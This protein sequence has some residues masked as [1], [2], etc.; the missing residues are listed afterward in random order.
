MKIVIAPDSFK[1][2]LSAECVA[3]AIAAGVRDA[4]PDAEILCVPM[5]DGGEG[6]LDAV[7]AATH[8]ERRYSEVEG[9]LG[10]PVTAQWGWLPGTLTAVI[11]MAAASGIHLVAPADRDACKA[12]T[13]GTGQLIVEAIEAGAQRI[14]LGFGGS[15]TNDGGSGMLCALGALFLDSSGV[16][17][18]QGG[19]D[20]QRLHYL[21]LGALDARL[22][23]IAFEVA[24][25]VDSPLCGPKGASHV[26]GPQK[27]ATPEQVLALDSALERYADIC[28]STFG[29][30][31]RGFKGA[32]AAGGIGYAAKMFLHASFRPGVE[33]VADLSNLAEAVQGAD[34]VITG[35]GRIDE[36]TLYGKTPA[37]V[38]AVAMAAGVPV[39]AIAGTLGAG[40]QRLRGIGISAAFSIT[41]GPMTLEAACS[42]AAQLLRERSSEVMRLWCLGR[43]ANQPVQVDSVP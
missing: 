29:R 26:F 22:Q 39:I 19:L 34:L 1:E 31:E 32:G 7:L 20:L 3:Q 12:S 2:S 10:Q 24:C 11:E 30:D 33:L 8:G 25:D 5:A 23:A 16:A 13:Y 6:T 18:A 35:E 40:Y 28:M 41:S 4:M 38:A 42:G 37:G 15:A 21:E 14:I 36:Q 43:S 27:G 17:I 9:P